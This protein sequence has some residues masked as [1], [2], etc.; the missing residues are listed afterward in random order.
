MIDWIAQQLKFIEVIIT[1]LKRNLYSQKW[2]KFKRE[3]FK[4]KS[5]LSI[6]YNIKG[7]RIINIIKLNRINPR[8]GELIFR[9]QKR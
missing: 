6:L 1:I 9:T 7:I 4:A 5:I 8:I 2:V 3:G